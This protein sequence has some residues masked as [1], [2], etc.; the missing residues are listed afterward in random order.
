[1]SVS[2]IM[3]N[4]NGLRFTQDAVASVLRFSPQSELI[5]VDNCSSDGDVETLSKTF[6]QVTLIS[7][8]ENVGFGA[9]NNRGAKVAKG[10]FLFFL[11]NDT[12]LIE[13][14]PAHLASFLD[15]NPSVAAC[16]P[17]LL[18]PD[19]AFQLSFGLDPS[20][21]NEW[22]VRRMQRRV[23]RRDQSYGFFLER[24]YANRNINW[25][26]GAAL[27]VRRDVFHKV[28]GFDEAFFIYFEEADLCRRIRE[29]GFEIR[30]VPTTTV[31]HYLGSAAQAASDKLSHEYR[32]SQVY[33]Y[34][35][36]LSILSVLFLRVY[37]FFRRMKRRSKNS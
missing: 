34:R 21:L 6:P 33:Y 20:I 26:T 23:R 4:H 16:G 17:K 18:Y 7:L 31:F 28:G 24:K 30:Y 25:V 19:G 2:V 29:L 32:K 27:M 36:H 11:N 13:D 10:N 8:T 22:V 35:K 3:V 12:F 9:G 1:M 14:T 15:R 5:V 37:L